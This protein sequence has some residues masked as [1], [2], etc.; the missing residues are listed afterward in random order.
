VILKIL[1]SKSMVNLASYILK[2]DAVLVAT[3]MESVDAPGLAR[4]FGLVTGLN[5][6]KHKAI[7]LVISHPLGERVPLEQAE[8]EIREALKG[9]GY[10]N[11]PFHAVEHFDGTKQHFHIATTPTDYSGKRIDR[12]GDRFEAKRIC[13]RLEKEAGLVA[14]T[15]YKDRTQ[16]APEVA[17]PEVQIPNLKDALFAA[18][19]PAIKRSKTIG[20]LA[21]DL[22]RHGIQMEAT[23]GAKGAAGLGFRLLGEHG[24]YLKASEVHSSFSLAKL[25]SKHGLTYQVGR[26]DAHLVAMTKKPQQPIQPV[27]AAMTEPLPASPRLQDSVAA[28]TRRILDSYKQRST[29]AQGPFTVVAPAPAKRGGPQQGFRPATPAIRAALLSTRLRPAADA[30]A[31]DAGR[32]LRPVVQPGPGVP[33]PSRPDHAPKV[34]A[35]VP[36]PAQGLAGAQL[37]APGDSRMRPR[38]DSRPDLAAALPDPGGRGVAP[39]HGGGVADPGSP[40]AAGPRVPAAPGRASGREQDRGQRP[41]GPGAPRQRQQDAPGSAHGAS[42]P[43]P[44]PGARAGQPGVGSE[45]GSGGPGGRTAPGLSAAA[46]AQL[47]IA[48]QIMKDLPR[49][50]PPRSSSMSP[51][52]ATRLVIEA[53]GQKPAMP[54]PTLEPMYPSRPSVVNERGRLQPKVNAEGVLFIGRHPIIPDPKRAPVL[55]MAPPPTEQAIQRGQRKPWS[56]EDL[57]FYEQEKAIYELAA[58]EHT[59]ACVRAGFKFRHGFELEAAAL[60]AP[61]VVEPKVTPAGRTFVGPFDITQR[62]EPPELVLHPTRQDQEA[63]DLALDTW[64][65]A[66]TEHERQVELARALPSVDNLVLTGNSYEPPITLDGEEPSYRPASQFGHKS[67][68]RPAKAP[69]RPQE[70]SKPPTPPKA[71]PKPPE[72]P[73]PKRSFGRGR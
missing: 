9:L 44:A 10:E 27:L 12:G 71:A 47:L 11:C 1:A 39:G 51:S 66:L 21:Q 61:R 55:D 22:L 17:A 3:N 68:E 6:L 62:P 50:K 37:E 45:R 46:T 60:K 67:P 70:P 42:G 2:D 7:H 24:G 15:S 29:Y 28:I 53:V 63:Q 73:T 26:D 72:P 35:G 69:D 16:A 38:H 56:A 14:V 5:P 58:R 54:A 25:Q 52:K 19:Q 20:E 32:P 34:G 8:H 64:R 40:A 65:Q 13:R 33:A 4:E 57:A 23:H 18:I 48:Q 30:P 43:A 49:V 41:S 36:N 31:R 59:R